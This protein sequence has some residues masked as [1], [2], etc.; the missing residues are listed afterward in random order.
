[1]R[2]LTQ[3][4]VEAVSGGVLFGFTW[5]GLLGSVENIGKDVIV[6]AIARVLE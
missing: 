4:E 6:G 3:N 2:E 1:M 5:K